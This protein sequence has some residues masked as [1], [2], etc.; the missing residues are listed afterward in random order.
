MPTKKIPSPK[1]RSAGPENA[2]L[3]ASPSRNSRLHSTLTRSHHGTP[4][5]TFELMHSEM[6]TF[7]AYPVFQ[8]E[9]A[10]RPCT[11]LP[12]SR[13]ASVRN[14]DFCFLR[15]PPVRG[16]FRRADRLLRIRIDEFSQACR[17][18]QEASGWSWYGRWSGT[19]MDDLTVLMDM[20]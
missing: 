6:L 1:L 18:A 13:C 8:D 4:I 11:S 5:V 19:A 12:C 14:A 16:T 17:Q 9:K 7:A 2:D 15:C 10:P 3:Q 20:G